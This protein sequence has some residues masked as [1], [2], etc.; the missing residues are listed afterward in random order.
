[1][2]TF[3]TVHPTASR[4]IIL[5]TCSDCGAA[6][7]SSSLRLDN[8]VIYSCGHVTYATG[9]GDEWETICPCPHSAYSILSWIKSWWKTNDTRYLGTDIA[10]AVDLALAKRKAAK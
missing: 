6:E 7:H 5:L 2:N 8:H 3:P 4:P 9:A 1:M 10:K